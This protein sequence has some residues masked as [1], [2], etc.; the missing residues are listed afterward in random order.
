MGFGPQKSSTKHCD[1]INSPESCFKSEIKYLIE[2]LFEIGVTTQTLARLSIE[3][4][5][6][7][8]QHLKKMDEVPS[9]TGIDIIL[10]GLGAKIIQ[11]VRV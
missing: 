5:V 3:K 7:I 10:H 6:T 11:L 8:A 2:M 1:F 4:C 9:C